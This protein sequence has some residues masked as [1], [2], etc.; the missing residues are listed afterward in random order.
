MHWFKYNDQDV[1]Y[2]SPW[3]FLRFIEKRD[4]GANVVDFG[5][6]TLKIDD[7]SQ[8]TYWTSFDDKYLV[9]DSFNKNEES[10]LQASKTQALIQLEFDF[11]LADDTVPDLPSRLFPTLLSKSKARAFVAFKQVSNVKE[12]QAERRVLF[13]TRTTVSE[14]TAPQPMDRLPNYHQARKNV[15]Q[16]YT[17]TRLNE[18][19]RT[20]STC[21]LRDMSIGSAKT[22]EG[23]FTFTVGKVGLFPRLCEGLSQ[24]L[25]SVSDT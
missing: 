13:V 15:S 11:R 5:G 7:T 6:V 25:K 16:A 12:D 24:A 3:E 8:P 1:K 23:T 18:S 9:L 14:P 22:T 20:Q 4:T 21:P 2:L 10:T 17:P 19:P